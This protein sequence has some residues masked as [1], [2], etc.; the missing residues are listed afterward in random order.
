MKRILAV[1]VASAFIAACG[2]DDKP[3]QPK[4][5]PKTESQ[6]QCA[7]NYWQR[8]C[9]M[10]NENSS[11]LAPAEITPPCAVKATVPLVATGGLYGIIVYCA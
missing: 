6:W 8:T 5:E 10:Y 7:H 4:P 11:D 9:I 2:S 3:D 1:L